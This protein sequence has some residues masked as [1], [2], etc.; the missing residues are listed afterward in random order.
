MWSF[1]II[2]CGLV[3]TSAINTKYIQPKRHI[4]PRKPYTKSIACRI[5][6]TRKQLI[7]REQMINKSSK[8]QSYE[9]PESK[10]CI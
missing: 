5:I 2:V 7:L 4:Q 1:I 8:I 3:A 9:P 10:K 6:N